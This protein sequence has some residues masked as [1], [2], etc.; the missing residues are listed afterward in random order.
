MPGNV[1]RLWRLESGSRLG[2][3]AE[4]DVSRVLQARA[5]R[6]NGATHA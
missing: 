2:R 5:T 4:L 1:R 3:R 6:Q